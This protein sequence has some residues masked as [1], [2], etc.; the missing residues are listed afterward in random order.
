MSLNAHIQQN[1]GMSISDR[2]IASEVFSPKPSAKNVRLW[3]PGRRDI[4][5][6]RVAARRLAS[7]G[8]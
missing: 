3:L 2:E 4:A 6:W 7:A 5:T 1:S 8:D